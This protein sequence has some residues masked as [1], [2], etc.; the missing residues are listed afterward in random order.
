MGKTS[1][2]RLSAKEKKKKTTTQKYVERNIKNASKNDGKRTSIKRQPRKLFV[3]ARKYSLLLFSKTDDCFLKIVTFFFF[4]FVENTA[5][6][7][8]FTTA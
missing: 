2:K 6:P 1:V 3:L 8:G 5:V 7:P 4:P